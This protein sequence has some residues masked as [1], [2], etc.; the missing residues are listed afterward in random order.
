MMEETI[1]CGSTSIACVW[2]DKLFSIS[3]WPH[4]FDLRTLSPI[5]VFFFVNDPQPDEPEA[6][7]ASSLELTVC[8]LV[9]TLGFA[10]M[11]LVGAGI[12]PTDGM[13]LT[14]P[15][16]SSDGNWLIFEEGLKRGRQRLMKVDSCETDLS[17]YT[18]NKISPLSM[19]I[20]IVTNSIE[21][22]CRWRVS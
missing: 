20:L 21:L 18:L 11:R 9:T 13:L 12:G 14:R 8:R 19:C 16:S 17:A 6:M 10:V 4:R 2:S 7:E 22:S 3:D 1:D 15:K 5:G